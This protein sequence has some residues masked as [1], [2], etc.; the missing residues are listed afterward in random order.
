MK[1]ILVI[2]DDPALSGALVML[3]NRHG[4]D[5][6][7]DTNP[8]SGMFKACHYPYDAVILDNYFPN[9]V[10][11]VEMEKALA[12]KNLPILM[13]T[14]SVDVKPEKARVVS[15]NLGPKAL[16]SEINR[17]INSREETSHV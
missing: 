14:S 11:G 5:V 12:E 9:L 15:K 16:I 7:T 3:L 2:D 17:L 1:K 6:D 10:T 13:F 8:I 4:F